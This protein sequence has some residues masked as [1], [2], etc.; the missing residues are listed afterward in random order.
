MELEDER[1]DEADAEFMRAAREN[2]ER[3]RSEDLGD[4]LN[5][6]GD[7]E[8]ADYGEESVPQDDTNMT[9]PQDAMPSEIDG[10]P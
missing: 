2:Y 6:A 9:T 4:L 10:K 5:D 8:Q 3:R 1:M 7:E